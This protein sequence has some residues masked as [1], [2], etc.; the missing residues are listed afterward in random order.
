MTKRKFYCFI[1]ESGKDTTWANTNKI[2]GGLEVFACLKD[3]NKWLDKYDC[4]HRFKERV[5]RQKAIKLVGK[6]EFNKIC[7]DFFEKE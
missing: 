4:Y 6:K 2:A 7:D 3:L 1:Y 5:S